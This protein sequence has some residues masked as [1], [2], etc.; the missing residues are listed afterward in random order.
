MKKEGGSEAKMFISHTL[1]DM[2]RL[3]GDFAM[4]LPAAPA[5]TREQSVAKVV[6]V[7]GT[8]EAQRVGETGWQPVQLQ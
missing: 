8:V 5:E 2:D 7:Q 6:S 3:F 4:P 1:C